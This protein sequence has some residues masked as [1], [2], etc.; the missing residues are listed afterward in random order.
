M[1]MRKWIPVIALVLCLLAFAAYRIFD[2]VVT[3]KVSP[4]ITV[5]ETGDILQVSMN[6][7]DSVLLQGVTAQDNKDGDVTDSLIIESVA[8]INQ[9]HQVVVTYAAFDRAGNVAKAQRTVQFTDYRSPRF[10]LSGPLAFPYGSRTGVLDY[11][12]AVDGLD[13]EIGY[14]VKTTM[15]DDTTITAEGIH[16]VL[17]RVTNSLSDTAELVI[18]V[19]VYDADQHD[20]DLFLKEYIVYILVGSAFDAESYLKEYRL[21][22][23]TT[24]LTRGISG[25][26]TL[27]TTGTVNVNEPGVYTVG[28]TVTA[29]RN[30][31]VYSG[32]SKL[33]VVVEG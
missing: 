21:F 9:N 32:Y 2:R 17:F 3:D 8:N 30:G 14:R 5:E 22:G 24:D 19:E 10:T 11:I 6:D 4:R 28:Y 18:P 23:E 25:G 12:G 26:L 15:M 1:K 16:N 29:V 13:G 33:V 20:A 7:P 27:D 31:L